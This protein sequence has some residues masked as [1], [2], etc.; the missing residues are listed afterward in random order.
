MSEYIHFVLIKGVKF[1]KRDHEWEEA[2]LNTRGVDQGFQVNLAS[3]LLMLLMHGNCALF[4][5]MEKL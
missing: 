4:F 5:W 3:K 1:S 2:E